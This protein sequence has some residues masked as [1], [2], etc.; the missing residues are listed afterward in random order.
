MIIFQGSQVQKG[1]LLDIG[2]CVVSLSQGS[3]VA[4]HM[5]LQDK[6]WSTLFQLISALLGLPDRTLEASIVSE[7][8]LLNLSKL[9]LAIN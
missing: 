8:V 1:T 9:L 5:Q 6:P 2:E 4:L 3:G 7:K